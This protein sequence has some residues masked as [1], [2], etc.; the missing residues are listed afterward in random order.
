MVATNLH[1][2]TQNAAQLNPILD[3]KT[4]VRCQFCTGKTMVFRRK[5]NAPFS[6]KI[7]QNGARHFQ[8]KNI[9]FL[10]K[11]DN[12]HHF[13]KTVRDLIKPQKRAKEHQRSA[14]DQGNCIVVGNIPRRGA[15]PNYR[16]CH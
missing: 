5:H 16:L 4:S 11:T 8:Q 10:C 7:A 14:K 2:Q 15:T 9:V 13:S 12:T 1:K 6:A 3:L